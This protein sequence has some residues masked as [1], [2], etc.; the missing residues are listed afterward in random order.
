MSRVNRFKDAA[1]SGLGVACPLGLSRPEIIGKL[2]LNESGIAPSA[3][4]GVQREVAGEAPPFELRSRLKKPKSEKLM[5]RSVR[6]AMLALKD[7]V[8]SSGLDLDAADRGRV[9]IEM[10]SGHTGID[11][12]EF[13]PAFQ[14]AWHGQAERDFSLLGGRASR[15]IDAYFS[16][17]SLANAGVGFASAEYDIHGP[18]NNFVQNDCASGWALAAAAEDLDEGQ[19]DAVLAGG[20]DSLLSKSVYLASS[21]AGLL[22]S[23]RPMKPFAAGRAGVTLAEGAAFFVVESSGSIESRGGRPL[24]YLEAF[25]VG[26]DA[27][28]EGWLA[29]GLPA[30]EDDLR[31]AFATGLRPDYVVARGLGAGGD[32][33][34]ADLLRRLGVDPARITA[35]KGW[36]GY[37]GAATCAVELA[38]TI[39]AV[40]EG[41]LPSPLAGSQP[42]PGLPL[43]LSIAPLAL[44]QNEETLILLL[45]GAWSGQASAL[46]VRVK[47]PG[48]AQQ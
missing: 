17:R 44:P 45:A 8:E 1:V 25:L 15:L 48:A 34:E 47:G 2:R 12:D 14:V 39:H 26:G 4:F 19:A 7:A 10:S 16:L 33:M 32:G 3:V 40:R 38:L 30:L 28:G 27:G 23:G 29:D 6:L 11:Y 20:Y 5:S 21:E 36:T 18:S 31:E 37:L 22:D 43:K 9:A 24:A 46:W 35:W 42:D 13:F 41:F